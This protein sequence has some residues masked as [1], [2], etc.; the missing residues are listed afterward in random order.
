MD[1]PEFIPY[2]QILHFLFL[3]NRSELCLFRKLKSV[4]LDKCLLELQIVFSLLRSFIGLLLDLDSTI[5]F[6]GR[7]MTLI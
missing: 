4:D 5:S 2:L 3:W 1:L 7:G 6:Q